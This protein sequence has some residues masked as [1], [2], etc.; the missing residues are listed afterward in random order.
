MGNARPISGDSER[1]Y[2]REVTPLSEWLVGKKA[3][4][5]A[6]GMSV[7]TV[8]RYLRQYPDFPAHRRGGTIF[9]SPAALVAWREHREIERCPTCGADIP[10]EER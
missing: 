10:R 6:I 4:A 3:V 5:N 8:K 7:S 9:V 2:A 1:T